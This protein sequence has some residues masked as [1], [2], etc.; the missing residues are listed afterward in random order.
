[1]NKDEFDNLA[2]EM[3][4]DLEHT[5]EISSLEDLANEAIEAMEEENAIEKSDLEQEDISE[6]IVDD[7]IDDANLVFETQ[8]KTEEKMKKEKLIS[9]IKK[10]WNKLGGIEKA[11]WVLGILLVIAIIILIIIF[12]IPEKKEKEKVDDRTILEVDNYRFEDGKLIFLDNKEEIGEYECDNKDQKLCEVAYYSE[13]NSYDTIKVVDEK[14]ESIPIRSSIFNKRYVFVRDG[15]NTLKLYD[16]K[17]KKIIKEGEKIRLYENDYVVMSSD[18]K[19]GLMAFNN[20]EMSLKIPYEYSEIHLISNSEN[21]IA[22]VKKDNNY[23][24]ADLDNK[25]LTK[26]FSESIVGANKKHLKVKSGS[27]YKVYDYEGNETDIKDSEYVRLLEDY[28]ISVKDNALYVFDYEGNRYNINGY[29]LHNNNYDGLETYKDRKLSKT[30]KAFDVDGSIY[31]MNLTI[32][33]GDQTENFSINLAEGKLSKNLIYMNYFDGTIYFYDDVK[34][35]NLIG[36]YGCNNKNTVSEDTKTLE[37]CRIAKE[38]LYRETEA[39]TKEKTELGIGTIPV[40]GKRYIFILD[41]DTI[42]LYDLKDSKTMATYKGVDTSSYTGSNDDLIFSD[43][44]NIP[45]IGESKN[46]GHYGVAKISMEG[47]TSVISFNHKSIKRLGDYYVVEDDNNYSLYS[48][49]GTEKTSKIPARIVDYNGK[50][51]KAIKDNQYF[52]YDFTGNKIREN[53]AYT[54]LELYNDY[55]AAIVQNTVHIFDYNGVDYV[56]NLPK[57]TKDS[58]K[59]QVKNF[60]NEKEGALSFKVSK[61]GKFYVVSIGT[62]SGDYE[63]VSIPTTIQ[64]NEKPKTDEGDSNE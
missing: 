9:K 4:R 28:I 5:I 8:I 38:S 48:F 39:N 26:A 12:A 45:Y 42:N 49:D 7:A 54:Y 14:G 55:Y 20:D 43:A 56:E 27:K 59:V 50:Y 3:N 44:I 61:E 63:K 47:V 19:E 33:N 37:T 31:V 46:S 53:E 22:I 1:M 10:K 51:L 18:E 25:I 32:Y 21:L 41:G 40:F 36:S 64:E 34:K 6:S 13:D 60:Y 11:L 62:V 57:E 17:E 15:E 30:E 24:L 35:E 23:Y 58:L 16:I 52:V 2:N 29:R